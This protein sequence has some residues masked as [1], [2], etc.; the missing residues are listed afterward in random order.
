P[1]AVGGAR[2]VQDAR[3]FGARLGGRRS[4]GRDRCTDPERGVGLAAVKLLPASPVE[5]SLEA[6]AFVFT[7]FAVAALAVV[8]YGEDYVIPALGFGIAIAGH[9]VGY[10]CRGRG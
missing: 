7:G 6:R 5:N 2:H 9:I 3:G 10:R 1:G 8:L 4:G